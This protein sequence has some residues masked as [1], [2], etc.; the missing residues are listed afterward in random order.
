MQSQQTICE[1]T[2]PTAVVKMVMVV[3]VK[4]R[5]G[6]GGEVGGGCAHCVGHDDNKYYTKL[7]TITNC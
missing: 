1:V 6:G 4:L 3:R 7:D 2:A 5:G